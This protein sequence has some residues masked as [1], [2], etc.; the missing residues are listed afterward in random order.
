MVSSNRWDREEGKSSTKWEKWP[1]S[2]HYSVAWHGGSLTLHVCMSF[3]TWIVFKD[4]LTSQLCTSSTHRWRK[5]RLMTML[6]IITAVKLHLREA[7]LCKRH[8]FLQSSPNVWSIKTTK[9]LETKDSCLLPTVWKICFS[10][11]AWVLIFW[12]CLGV[13][14]HEVSFRIPCVL[15]I[16]QGIAELL[17]H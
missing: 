13:S 16:L 2:T 9:S 11:T 14:L 10:K 7:Q 3:S 8:Y 5:Y 17:F 1:P 6:L 12:K 15:H 4:S